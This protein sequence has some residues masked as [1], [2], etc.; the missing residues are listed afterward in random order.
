MIRPATIDDLPAILELGGR[1][2][3]ESRFRALE[4]DLAKV[5]RV[6]EQL[7]NSDDGIV[8]LA[9]VNGRIVGGI[10]GVVVEHWFS[11]SKVAQDFALFIEPEHRGGMLAVRLLRQYEK[12]AFE[13]GAVAVEMG[14][15][16]GVH[17]EQTA[18]MLE[19]LGFRSV[20]VLHSKEF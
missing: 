10:A 4:F 18:K 1:M 2:H 15:N 12:W 20:A 3:L 5:A 16:T 11:V 7:I 19:L 13:Q 14:I 8:M 6:F 17:V 9:E